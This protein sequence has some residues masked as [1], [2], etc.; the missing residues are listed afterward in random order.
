MSTENGVL[1]PVSSN[2]PTED[3]KM[4]EETTET[5]PLIVEVKTEPISSAT[6]SLCGEAQAQPSPSTSGDENKAA[7]A[8]R[9]KRKYNKRKLAPEECSR[10]SVR[11]NKNAAA[12][13]EIINNYT[14]IKDIRRSR[15]VQFPKGLKRIPF[16]TPEKPLKEN[17][18]LR[19]DMNCTRSTTRELYVIESP[20]KKKRKNAK[21]DESATNSNNVPIGVDHQAAL[22]ELME[23]R[24]SAV[25]EDDRDEPIWIPECSEIAMDEFRETYELVQPQYGS[26]IPLDSFLHRFME[27]GYSVEK[28]LETLE[29]ERDNLPQPFKPFTVA[30]QIEFEKHIRR[31]S[32]P[33]K[34]KSFK[35]MQD[36][37]L[38]SYH[39]GEIINYYYLT[40]RH[41]CPD[42]IIGRCSCHELMRKKPENLVSRLECSNCTKDMRANAEKSDK[43]CLVCDLYFTRTGKQRTSPG[44][45]TDEE[46]EFL[47]Y[48]NEMELQ[49]GK[50][51]T[52][53]EVEQ[54]MEDE[55]ITEL[56]T[57]PLTQEEITS[58]GTSKK[59]DRRTV[60][61]ML[62][63]FKPKQSETCPRKPVE[64]YRAIHT[65]EFTPE[66][67]AKLV[68]SF[69]KNS[70]DISKVCEDLNISPLEARVFYRRYEVELNAMPE[71]NNN[72]K[73]K[74]GSKAS[75]TQSAGPSP[76]DENGGVATRK[77]KSSMFHEVPAAAAKRRA[78]PI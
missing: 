35:Y 5:K 58:L 48:W 27:C 18:R 28:M 72:K 43:L 51:M 20:P 45:F 23:A 40:K 56:E 46:E 44:R 73:K 22:P 57:R 70:N 26:V 33:I 1:L 65:K 12:D 6:P 68:R 29:S 71:N 14:G 19:I 4:P 38:R 2:S 75:P 24:A 55:R 3:K 50:E 77:R 59:R 78:K 25:D 39:L 47:K 64:D 7:P 52:I 74:K 49:N 31:T 66:E 13:A 30:Q 15:N 16:V 9:Q 32:G 36:R 37:F 8:T 63:P 76:K 62:A 34:S 10:K 54:K 21:N 17:G 53:G 67:T 61:V 42:K 41:H 60:A 11:I 69:F